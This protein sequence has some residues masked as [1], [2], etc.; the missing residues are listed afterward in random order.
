MR[1]KKLIMGV[2]I[3]AFIV[4]FVISML[5]SPKLEHIEDTNGAENYQLTTITDSNIILRD[6]GA[7]GLTRVK[8]NITNTEEFK[9]D[10][11]TGVEEIYGVNIIGNRM[12]ITITNLQVD[13]GNFKAVVVHND[14]IVHEFRN[15]EMMETFTLENPKGY[16]AIR[17]AGESADFY[18][19]YDII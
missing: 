8:N 18:L 14:E 15:N 6:I 1:I 10:K 3:I 11:F 9:S 5:N 2:A 16:V 19:T 7:K 13:S 12:D 4:V 17:V